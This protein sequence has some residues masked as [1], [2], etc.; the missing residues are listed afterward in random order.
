MEESFSDTEN[1]YKNEPSMKKDRSLL[2]M[3]LILGIIIGVMGY[4]TLFVDDPWKFFQQKEQPEAVI[5]TQ[6]ELLDESSE[7]SEEEVR[8]S[9]TKFIEAFYYDQRRGYFDP[10]SYFSPITETF[11]NYHNLTYQQLKDLYWKRKEDRENLSRNWIV[12]SLDFERFDSRIKATYW[13][14]EKFFRPSSNEQQSMDIKYEMTIDENGKIVSFKELEIKN[15]EVFKVVPDT[16]SIDSSLMIENPISA[17]TNQVFDFSIVEVKPEF[18]GGPREWARY[19]TSNI[20]YPAVA[21]ENN[22]QGKVMVAFIV[23]KEGSIRDVKIRQ[24]I[25]GGCDEEALRIVRSSPKWKPGMVKGVA[26]GTYCVFPISF[27]LTN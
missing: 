17:S 4:L 13:T 10:P 12:S 26:V 22:V 9:L 11:Y 7:M 21:R 1:E 19:L 16:T 15:L 24:G 5:D 23:D 3:G 8:K 25:G 18:P 27:Q 14:K 6:S 20:K 2:Y